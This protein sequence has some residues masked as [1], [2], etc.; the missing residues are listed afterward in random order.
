MMRKNIYF[1]RP[2]G[3][4]GPIKIGSSA[5]PE[6]RLKTYQIWSP[7]LLELV[8]YC[9]AHHNT[10]RWM[11]RHFLADWLHGEWFDWSETLQEAIDHVVVHGCLPDWVNPPTNPAEYRAFLEQYP[12]G[13]TKQ[14]LRE[15]VA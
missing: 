6:Q 13:K 5:A 8:A 11:H 9:P 3:E 12:R 1:L 4:R 14:S 10:E 7:Q 2:K 15:K